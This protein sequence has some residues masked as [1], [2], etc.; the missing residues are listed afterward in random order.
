MHAIARRI[1]AKVLS[2]RPR[3]DRS[4][5]EEQRPNSQRRSTPQFVPFEGPCIVVSWTGDLENGRRNNSDEERE[6]PDGSLGVLYSL[7]K[8]WAWPALAHRCE[9]HPWE[10]SSTIVNRRGD[11]ALHWAVFGNPPL[12]VIE[13]LLKACPDLVNVP[14]E[15]K[16]LPLHL[17]CCY[18][19]SVGILQ[20][21]IEVNPKTVGI[22]NGFGFYP[23]HLLCDCGCRAECLELVLRYPDAART[24]VEKDHTYERTPL[25]ILNQRKNLG[26]FAGQVEELRRLRQRQRDA[27][28]CGNWTDG[29]EVKLQVKITEAKDMEFWCKAR[30]IILAEYCFHKQLNRPE[31]QSIILSCLEIEECPPSLVEYA[32]LAYSEELVLPDNDGSLPLH[33]VCARAIYNKEYQWLILEILTANPNAARKRDSKRRLPLEILVETRKD[34]IWSETLKRLI[35]AHPVALDN[36]QID[37]RLY[38]LILEKIG[39]NKNTLGEVFEILRV[40]PGIFADFSSHRVLR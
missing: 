4:N 23:L 8:S 31:N 39:C 35:L 29:D 32:I 2:L 7:A 34:V 25:C 30:M 1:A 3:R 12:Y 40:S 37:A 33:H 18:R 24:I 9:T 6:Y 19:A 17:A 14:N 27:L 28:Q 38:P 10:A 21:L 11:T 26:Y 36:L 20:S 16:Q 5:D 15:S 13:A 22:R